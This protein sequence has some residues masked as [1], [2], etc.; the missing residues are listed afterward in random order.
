MVA[1]SKEIEL[2]AVSSPNA[3]AIETT[4]N[5]V[6]GGI[7]PLLDGDRLSR[8]EFERRYEAMP[9]VKKAEL[10]EGI[11]Y[12]P[13]PVR[14]RAH[15]SPHGSIVIWVG[16][17]KVNTPGLE[18]GDNGSVR[19]DDIN[20]PQPDAMLFIP[21]NLGG[22]SE[23]SDDDYVERAPELVVEV[24]SSSE[25]YDLGAKLTAYQ[26]NGVREYVVW[27]ASERR[28]DW[29]VLENDQFKRLEPGDDGI[30]RS[31]VFP[32]LWL[33]RAALVR[34]DLKSVLAV[35]DRGVQSDEHQAFALRLE[36]VRGE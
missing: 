30:L 7:P 28:V 6:D 34:G 33:D 35:L 12:M 18:L 20:E 31:R 17:Y 3:A 2:M 26:R 15:S 16:N 10:I 9:H 27:R 8:L 5:T 14:H 21:K 24:A 36:Q 29:F 4:L 32:G 22:Q 13:S 19:L 23:I 1:G 25:S 11:V